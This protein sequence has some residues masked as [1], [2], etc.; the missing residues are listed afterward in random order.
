MSGNLLPVGSSPKADAG[1]SFPPLE[2]YDVLEKIAD[3]GMSTVYK[4]RPK[5]GG[6]LVAIKVISAD[7]AKSPVLIK[8]FEQEFHT[9][10][11]LDH[12]NVVRSLDYGMADNLPYLVMEYVPGDSLGQRIETSGKLPPREAIHIATQ[13]AQALDYLH[14]QGVIHR[15][16]KPDNILF[17]ADGRAKVI[18]LGLI[19]QVV[20]KTADDMNLTR[21]G[22]GLGTPNFMA[23]EQFKNAKNIDH[24]CDIYGLAA[25][26]YMAITGELPFAAS[27]PFQSLK[28][29]ACNELKPPRLLVPTLPRHVEQ[30]ILRAMSPSAKNRP[31]SCGEFVKE[32]TARS[33]EEHPGSRITPTAGPGLVPNGFFAAANLDPPPAAPTPASDCS[34]PPSLPLS[35]ASQS[36]QDGNSSPAPAPV[37][38]E[39]MG[40]KQW[41][42]AA[43][44]ALVGGLAAFLIANFR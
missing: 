38:P 1:G 3:G 27:H 31:G 5:D 10:A 13:V 7:K 29:K 19:K 34:P 2:K 20:E 32:L 24:R 33:P 16:V 6:D 14:Q 26:L 37:A 42:L 12:P 36:P 30:A 17:T 39:R 8:R 22:Q 21:P 40:W 15:D 41:A 44:L 11:R 23:P 28:M 25:T 4:A 9:L 35:S 18:D 43:A